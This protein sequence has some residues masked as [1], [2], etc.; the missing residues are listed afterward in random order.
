MTAESTRECREQDRRAREREARRRF[1]ELMDGAARHSVEVV[2]IADLG[3]VPV[4]LP[5]MGGETWD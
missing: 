2:H 4:A 1:A 5:P 3:D